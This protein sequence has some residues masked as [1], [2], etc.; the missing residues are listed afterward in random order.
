MLGFFGIDDIK[1]VAADA[2]AFGAE[3]AIAKGEAE[4]DALAA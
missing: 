4:V 2:M 3:T 1:F